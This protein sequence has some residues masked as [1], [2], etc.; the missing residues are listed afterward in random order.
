MMTKM[1]C[2]RLASQQLL[3]AMLELGQQNIVIRLPAS[4]SNAPTSKQH[5]QIIMKKENVIWSQ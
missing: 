3:S 2:K 4:Y 1:T 5:Q